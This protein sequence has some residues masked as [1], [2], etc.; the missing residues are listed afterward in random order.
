MG[1]AS[2][3][4]HSAARIEASLPR[5]SAEDDPDGVF[6]GGLVVE[7]ASR[8][9]LL[10][11]PA[12]VPVGLN[13]QEEPAS[14]RRDANGAWEFSPGAARALREYLEAHPELVSAVLRS[15]H[16]DAAE[17]S[18]TLRVGRFIRGV[19]TNVAHRARAWRD[20]R[21]PAKL[22]ALDAALEP[23]TRSPGKPR[24]P[25]S[26]GKRGDAEDRSAPRRDGA[27]T[28]GAWG[29]KKPDAA[30]LSLIHI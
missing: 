10:A 20:A 28:G 12:D 4:W 22:L 13:L 7:C 26:S 16:R 5:P 21:L 30:Q 15:A 14:A 11:M 17:G 19:P 25:S 9:G 29:E 18:G 1:D 6:G 24:K 8:A 2:D 3:E 27:S 23:P